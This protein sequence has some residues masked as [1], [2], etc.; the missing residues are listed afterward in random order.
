[1]QDPIDPKLRDV[2]SH[3]VVIVTLRSEVAP[4]DSAETDCGATT[5]AEAAMRVV[6]RRDSAFAEALFRFL[7]LN[8]LLVNF[9]L[10]FLT[11]EEQAQRR[12]AQFVLTVKNCHLF[13]NGV[14]VTVSSPSRRR[15][16]RLHASLPAS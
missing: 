10:S 5:K 4:A 12:R 1:M 3:V 11:E 6:T 2:E 16:R 9:R 7:F 8:M 14:N 13:V 15:R